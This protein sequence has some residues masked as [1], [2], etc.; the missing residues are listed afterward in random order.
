MYQNASEQDQ[1]DSSSESTGVD[2][3]QKHNDESPDSVMND[4]TKVIKVVKSF[5]PF[6]HFVNNFFF[7]FIDRPRNSLSSLFSTTISSTW[8]WIGIRLSIR[9]KQFIC[10]RQGTEDQWSGKIIM[11]FVRSKIRAYRR[12]ETTCHKPCWIDI[13]RNRGKCKFHPSVFFIYSLFYIHLFIDT[14]KRMKKKSWAKNVNQRKTYQLM[15]ES[16]KL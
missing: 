6:N 15:M 12:A 5:Y 8:G 7:W 1:P 13:W 16:T 11:W 10:H 4:E 14:M 9:N 3:P 2:L